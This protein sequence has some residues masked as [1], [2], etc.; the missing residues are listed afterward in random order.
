MIKRRASRSSFKQHSV[1]LWVSLSLSLSSPSLFLPL[2]SFVARRQIKSLTFQRGRGRSG[3]RRISSKALVANMVLAV[4]VFGVSAFLPLRGN[5]RRAHAARLTRLHGLLRRSALF[6]VALVAQILL[7]FRFVFTRSP[8]RAR[9]AGA[10]T[11]ALQRPARLQTLSSLAFVTS[12]AQ[13]LPFVQLTLIP[14]PAGIWTRAHE[15][16][17]VLVLHVVVRP[18]RKAQVLVVAFRRPGLAEI[19][20]ALLPLGA[21]FPDARALNPPRWSFLFLVRVVSRPVLSR[22]REHRDHR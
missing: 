22:E 6:Q 7:P 18:T 9:V 19:S 15:T 20:S 5:L 21:V 16:L 13:I 17:P 2:L 1:S 4:R 8:F 11:P 3:V 10:A 14:T 12:S